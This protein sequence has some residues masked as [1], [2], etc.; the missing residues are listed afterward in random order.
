MM[1]EMNEADRKGLHHF[2]NTLT[3]QAYSDPLS[4]LEACWQ[5]ALTHVRDQSL[6]NAVYKAALEWCGQKDRETF[7][8]DVEYFIQNWQAMPGLR[9]YVDR[10]LDKTAE[11]EELARLRAE[12]ARLT[13]ALTPSGGTKAA[14]WDE[15]HISY[16]QRVES[17]DDDDDDAWETVSIPVPWTVVKEIMAAIHA[18]AALAPAKCCTTNDG[19][20]A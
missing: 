19:A 7:P 8:A 4:A 16:E 14:Y 12:N 5:A 1:A 9:G 3:A 10:Q 15:F 18:R 20:A 11:S 6:K 2:I 13:E 17:D